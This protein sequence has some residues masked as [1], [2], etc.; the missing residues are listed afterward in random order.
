MWLKAGPTAAFAFALTAAAAVPALSRSSAG[1]D[2]R[3]GGLRIA[4][5]E[6]TLVPEARAIRPGKV[7][8][9]VTNRGR[10]V[11]AFRI[12]AANVS[13][14]DRFEARTR[15]LRPGQTARL[16]VQLSAGVYDIECPV[17]DGGID[18][19]ARGM[20]ALLRVAPNAPLLRPATRSPNRATISGFAYRPRTLTVRRG[21]TATWTNSDAAPHTVT[22][23]N[24]SFSSPQLGKGARYARRFTRTGRFA[25]VCALH[26]Q[27]QGV[28]VVR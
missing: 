17:D 9:V 15:A 25:Y 2:P 11:H 14:N 10:L 12:R 18:H 4:L 7:T 3:S 24:G 20:H 5:G 28:V 6:W 8:F 27:M 22:A 19:E 23:S 26:P 13:G 21:V 1:V 16:T